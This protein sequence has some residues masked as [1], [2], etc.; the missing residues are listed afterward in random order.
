LR[1]SFGAAVPAF[2]ISGDTA[3]ERLREAQDSGYLL[4]HQ[5]V[6]PM[7]LRNVLSQ[8]LKSD[9]VAGAA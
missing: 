7:K 3:P 4:L 5:P 2:L 9:N 8:L 6:R 1:A